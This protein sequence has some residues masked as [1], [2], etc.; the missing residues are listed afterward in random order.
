L[1][2]S[3]HLSPIAAPVVKMG[4]PDGYVDSGFGE[5]PILDEIDVNF[6]KA[7]SPPPSMQRVSARPA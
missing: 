5:L 3:G 7:K 2:A 1:D 6:G 4:W